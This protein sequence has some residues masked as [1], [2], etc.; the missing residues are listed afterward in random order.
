MHASVETAIE[1][2]VVSPYQSKFRLMSVITGLLLLSLLWTWFQSGHSNKGAPA[3]M[4]ADNSAGNGTNISGAGS[5]LAKSRYI[6]QLDEI[7]NHKP[8]KITP[9]EPDPQEGS[10]SSISKDFDVLVVYAGSHVNPS[11]V[12]E[13]V[14]E[15]L[16]QQGV[17]EVEQFPTNDAMLTTFLGRF[18][19][20][21]S[22]KSIK[23]SVHRI[24]GSPD[25]LQPD[26]IYIGKLDRDDLNG[27]WAESANRV[28]YSNNAYEIGLE[29]LVLIVHPENPVILLSKDQVAAMLSGLITDWQ[30]VRGRSG[31]INIYSHVDS[32]G[33]SEESIRSMIS[34]NMPLSDGIKFRNDPVDIV[35]AVNSDVFA[36]GMVPYPYA[37]D[38]KILGVSVAGMT[39][40]I[41]NQHTLSR[42]HYPFAQLIFLYTPPSSMNWLNEKF[43]AFVQSNP[44][45]TMLARVGYTVPENITQGLAKDQA[46]V[47]DFDRLTKTAMELSYKIH[48]DPQST[49]LSGSGYRDVQRVAEF[50]KE[51]DMSDKRLMIFGFTD[52]LGS[53]KFNVAL[54]E[55]RAQ[56]VAEMLKQYG[57]DSDI[58]VG[59]GAQNPMASNETIAGRNKNR[60]VELWLEKKADTSA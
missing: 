48:F 51:L 16:N 11:L 24:V 14:K 49:T 45:R 3:S 60:R 9:I 12:E 34:Q 26:E 47:W 35:N 6:D 13:L 52:S 19:D 59:F 54:S 36:I 29:S 5:A 30:Q 56:A 17:L 37:G 15:F 8:L 41:P 31:R 1:P 25:K 38:A 22:R 42:H 27:Q 57:V 23:V 55:K 43:K 46:T 21:S 4:P 58:V 40:I 53:P 50:L 44:G 20:H 18:G 33:N 39:P 32:N 10:E 7:Q 2:T 28:K